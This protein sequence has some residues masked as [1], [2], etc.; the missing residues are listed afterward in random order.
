[1]WGIEKKKSLSKKTFE[2]PLESRFK[3]LI[4]KSPIIKFGLL[5]VLSVISVLSIYSLNRSNLA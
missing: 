2:T 4:F 3:T 1:M 5:D